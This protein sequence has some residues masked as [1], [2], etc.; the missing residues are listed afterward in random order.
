M[1]VIGKYKKPNTYIIS[2]STKEY[3]YRGIIDYAL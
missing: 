1:I 3:F 2:Y